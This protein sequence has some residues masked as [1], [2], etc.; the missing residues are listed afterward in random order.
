MSLEAQLDLKEAKVD[1]LRSLEQ[2]LCGSSSSCRSKKRR[3][4]EGEGE[5]GEG[6]GEVGEGEGEEGLP[7]GT[8]SADGD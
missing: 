3:V 5:V 2:F 1:E 4:G 8:F 7:T 6:E